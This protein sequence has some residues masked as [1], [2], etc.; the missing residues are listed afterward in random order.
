MSRKHNICIMILTGREFNERYKNMTFYK[1]LN[2]NLIHFQHEYKNGLNIDAIKFFPYGECMAG[3]LYFCEELVSVNYIKLYGKYYSKVTI[4]DDA[5]VYIEFGKFKADRII[6]ND[7]REI[8][9]NDDKKFWE[10]ILS[11]YPRHIDLIYPTN[12]LFLEMW[13][14]VVNK[15][16][17]L[18]A[19]IKDQKF[20][21][22]AYYDLSVLSVQQKCEN[23]RYVKIDKI[24]PEKYNDLCKFAVKTHSNA[25]LY[26]VQTPELCEI[27]VRN[28][29]CALFYVFKQT[30]DLCELAVKQ[31]EHAL[32]YIRD[33]NVYKYL[34]GILYGSTM[35]VKNG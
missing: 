16:G 18:I 8:G 2:D 27:A 3:G 24:T 4:P 33:Q 30:Q 19:K 13:K 7:I 22:D 28:F 12:P 9:S 34:H 1:F 14:F 26:V 20:D 15:N 21:K 32:I 25:L 17:S 10:C 6:L 5:K 35:Q 23:I 31:N 11:L 29:G